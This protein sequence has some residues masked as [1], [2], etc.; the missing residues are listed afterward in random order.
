MSGGLRRGALTL[1]LALA[2][3]TKAEPPATGELVDAPA[4]VEFRAGERAALDKFNDALDRQRANKI[5]ELGLAE[6]IDTQVL[7]PWRELR[8]H[9]AAAAVP[10][11]DRELFATLTRYLGERENAWEAYSA[12]LH[13]GNDTAAAPHYAKYHE[14]DAAADTDARALGA[15]FR[16]LS[17]KPGS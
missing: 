9:V 12:A 2:S 7:P 8:A 10:A 4:I 5:D 16:R 15:M 6:A 17:P 13:A 11:P 14:Q 1:A 3:C